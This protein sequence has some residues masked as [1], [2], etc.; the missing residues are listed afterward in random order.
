VA[1]QRAATPSHAAQL[2]WTERGVLR[3]QADE[4]FVALARGMARLLD[5][6]ERSLQ[7]QVQGLNW[8]SPARRIERWGFELER[9]GDR[10]RQAARTQ[11]DSRATALVRLEDRMHRSFGP[12]AMLSLR[13]DLDRAESAL[14]QAGARFVRVRLEALRGLE[15]QLAALD[16][17]APLARGY[18]LVRGASG[19]VRSRQDVRA[20]D[21][22]R[23]QV[24]DGEFSAEVLP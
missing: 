20:G 6:R 8:H 17:A 22:I 21:E 1:D 11:L 2:L 14:E 24:A 9:L 3:Q 5:A 16:P 19:F 15:G 13:S 23:V 12:A 4:I 7:L 18:A 10:L